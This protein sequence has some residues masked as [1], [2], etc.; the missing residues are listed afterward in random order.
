MI[1]DSKRGSALICALKSDVIVELS[2][3]YAELSIDAL[4]ESKTLEAIPFVST[5]VGLYKVASSVRSQLFT[6]KIIRFLTHFSDL[7]DAERINMTERLNEND[8]F[9][10]KAGARLIE[11]IDRME[12]ENKPEVAAEFLKSFA[13]EEIDF[14]VLRRL[15]V[16]LERIPSFDIRELAAFVAIDPDQSVEMDEAFLDGLVNAGLGKSNGAWKSVIVP[17]E[18]GIA[19]VC[20][21]KL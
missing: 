16:A 19:F 2:K 11:I 15:L 8:K 3:E 14:N 17:T 13:R 10:G 18:L 21:G 5:V 9:A 6:E 20:A 7:P 4:I 1:E 12:S